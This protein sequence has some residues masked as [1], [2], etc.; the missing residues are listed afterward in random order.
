[1]VYRICVGF[2][3]SRSSWSCRNLLFPGV[4]VGDDLCSDS[5]TFSSIGSAVLGTFT[6]M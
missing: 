4:F 2:S 5:V 3:R 1:M 6:N